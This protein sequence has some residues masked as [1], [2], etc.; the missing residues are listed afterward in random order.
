MSM[1]TAPRQP[2]ATPGHQGNK[3]GPP[4]TKPRVQKATAAKPASK[5]TPRTSFEFEVCVSFAGEVRDVVKAV[6]ASLK[7]RKIKCFYDF[8]EQANLLGKDLFTYL[9]EIY[10]K[11]SRFCIMFISEH[12]PV[13]KWTN[14]ERQSIQ[15]RVF[16][17]KDD[18]L[19]P[20]RLDDTEVPGVLSTVGYIDGRRQTSSEIAGLIQAKVQGKKK[21]KKPTSTPQ[22]T[23]TGRKVNWT[24]MTSLRK[25]RR[26]LSDPI[27]L[28]LLDMTA[29]RAGQMVPFSDVLRQAGLMDHRK[30]MVAL[31]VLTKT[32]KREFNLPT[33]KATWPVE[34]HTN[35]N[36]DGQ[37]SYRM[38]P[39]VARAW[40]QTAT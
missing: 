11:K 2:R 6:V 32:I 4:A 10:R 8:D 1:R 13:K 16:E 35:V 29:A 31:G 24:Y 33:E 40:L 18:Y 20:V 7:R 38:P 17:G 5:R 28:T 21:P 22:A 25:L 9:D 15:A 19:I 14:H 37:T 27:T 30:G 23:G 12:Y 26:A 39:D 34:R 36:G 3:T